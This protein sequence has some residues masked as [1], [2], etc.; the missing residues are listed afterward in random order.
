MISIWDIVVYVFLLQRLVLSEVLLILSFRFQLSFFI[1]ACTCHRAV[2]LLLNP[3]VYSLFVIIFVAAVYP[4]AYTPSV[5][6]VPSD[7]DVNNTTVSLIHC[8]PVKQIA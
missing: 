4:A 2:M 8:I 3:Y 5:Q 1:C 6:S 7:G